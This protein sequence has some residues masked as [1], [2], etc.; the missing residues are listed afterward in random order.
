V[1]NA[2]LAQNALIDLE[3]YQQW[4]RIVTRFSFTL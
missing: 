3:P 2:C 4:G 1:L